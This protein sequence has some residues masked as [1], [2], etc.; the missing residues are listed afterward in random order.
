MGACVL[1]ADRW[2][3]SILSRSCRTRADGAVSA[4]PRGANRRAR[5]GGFSWR[6]ALER[7]GRMASMYWIVKM[8]QGD[9]NWFSGK[10]MA[11]ALCL[12]VR[13]VTLFHEVL[14]VSRFVLNSQN[15]QGAPAG[16]IA[17]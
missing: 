4:R 11:S 9:S 7:A 6:Q 8:F 13:P 3:R 14:E 17:C 16:G 15:F 12:S 1:A 10:W 2:C 5:V